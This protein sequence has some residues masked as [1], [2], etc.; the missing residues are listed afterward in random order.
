MGCPV[1]SAGSRWTELNCVP[2]D[3]Q[4]SPPNLRIDRF[5]IGSAYT[6]APMSDASAFDTL[7]LNPALLGKLADIGYVEMTMVQ[8]QALPEVLK[9]RDVIARAKTGSGKTAAFGLGLLDQLDPASF[10]VQALVLCPTRELADQVAKEVRRLAQAIPNIKILT[11]CGG[12]PLGPQN[13]SLQ[14][15][16]HIIVGTPGRVLKHLNKSTVTLDGLRTLVLDEADRMLDMGFMDELDAILAFVPKDRQTLLFSATYP[17]A[18]AGMSERVQ[19]NPITIDVTDDEQPVKIEQHWCSVTRENRNDQLLRALR[20]WGGGLNLVFCN[21]KIDCAEV[22]GFLRSEG[23]GTVALHGDLDQPQRTQ[24]LV[25]FANRSASVLV[26]TDVAARGLDVDDVDAVFNYELP[27]Q[28]EVYVHRI[29]RTGRAGKE[30]IAVSLVE[31]REMRRLID[32]ETSLTDSK[33]PERGIPD[34]KQPVDSLSAT[35]TTIQVSGG[36]KNK[37]RPGDLLG[38]LTAAGGV[39]GDV[40]GSI[41]LFDTVSYVA[42]QNA[43]AKK[44]VQQL[45]SRPIKGRKYR[46]RILK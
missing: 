21:T 10:R 14:H 36:R 44:A 29:G 5:D 11:L 19:R 43:Q 42:V 22:A 18:I 41:D 16:P 27:P 13:A 17:D 20:A 15:S 34:S 40:V 6:R 33:L 25:R 7:E 3:E 30:G 9:G 46:A 2:V 35:M 24:V 4:V 38:A 32:I 1:E 31:P 26:A 37:L 23:I 12:A 8:A 45:A 39:S 28:P